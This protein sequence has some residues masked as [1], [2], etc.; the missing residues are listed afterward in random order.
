M[1]LDGFGIDTS[2]SQPTLPLGWLVF[3][4]RVEQNPIS[5]KNTLFLG[6]GFKHALFSALL[7]EMIPFDLYFFRWVEATN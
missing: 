4:F 2:E 6:G 3:T 1:E 7:G 5:H